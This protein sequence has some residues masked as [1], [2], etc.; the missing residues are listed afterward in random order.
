MD[1][2]D[3]LGARLDVPQTMEEVRQMIAAPDNGETDIL[4]DSNG[5][6]ANVRR[7]A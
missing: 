2:F 1:T 5:I 7:L 6:V 3:A 4:Y